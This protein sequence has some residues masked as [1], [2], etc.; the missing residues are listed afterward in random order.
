MFHNFINCVKV[1]YIYRHSINISLSVLTEDEDEHHPGHMPSS[2]RLCHALRSP[3][4]PRHLV[5]AVVQPYGHQHVEECD[6]SQ[7]N[8]VID[9]RL[10]GDVVLGVRLGI[11]DVGVGGAVGYSPVAGRKKII[12]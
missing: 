3:D 9:E 10:D 6:Y 7:W 8:E 5:G 11:G 2:S 4:L 1:S 12:V